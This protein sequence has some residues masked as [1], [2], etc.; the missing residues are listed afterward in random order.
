MCCEPIAA[1]PEDVVDICPRCY[2]GIDADGITTEECCGYS[3][4]VCGCGWRPCDQS[5]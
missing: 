2:G 3:P 5:C 4:T 1:N